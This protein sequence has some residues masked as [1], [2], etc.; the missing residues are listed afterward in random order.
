MKLGSLEQALENQ[1]LF[2]TK[3]PRIAWRQDVRNSSNGGN[4]QALGP[5]I[6]TSMFYVFPNPIIKQNGEGKLV[7]KYLVTRSIKN[8]LRQKR[9]KHKK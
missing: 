3:S 6:N 7:K 9:K 2:L 4:R 5:T 8:K 1:D